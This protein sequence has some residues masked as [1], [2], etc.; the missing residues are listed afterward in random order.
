MNYMK[1]S[2]FSIILKTFLKNQHFFLVSFAILTF[3]TFF[4]NFLIFYIIVIIKI[5]LSYFVIS[6]EHFANI[7]IELFY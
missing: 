6:F 3:L 1:I 7:F 2:F 5:C 4:F